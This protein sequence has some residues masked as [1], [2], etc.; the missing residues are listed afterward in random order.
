MTMSAGRR[1]HQWAAPKLHVKLYQKLLHVNYFILNGAVDAEFSTTI[2]SAR[3]SSS[4]AAA[5]CASFGP[6]NHCLMPASSSRHCHIPI[7]LFPI[8]ILL[9]LLATHRVFAAHYYNNYHSLLHGTR[10]QLND[11]LGDLCQFMLRFLLI[12]NYIRLVVRC[13]TINR[14][15]L[16]KPSIWKM[17]LRNSTEPWFD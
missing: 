9:L 13:I 3:P 2:K 12:A 17:K 8:L 16:I 5:S 1:V 6:N 10:I 4:S 14:R 7:P 15:K 11:W